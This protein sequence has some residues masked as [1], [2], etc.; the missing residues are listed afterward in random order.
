VNG[1]DIVKERLR[2]LA[3]YV[4]D[5]QDYRAQA[6]SFQVYQDNKMLRR[7]V[8]R[9]L[10]VALEICLDIGRRLITLDGFRYPADNQDVFRVL[11]EER[12]VSE[13]LLSALLDMARFRNL[14]VHNYAHID[15]AKV[16]GILRKHLGDFDAFAR[17]I[18]DYLQ[19][20][21]GTLSDGS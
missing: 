16:Y 2:L 10:Q 3:E 14:V 13:P 19:P 8:E 5:L 1:D 18:V 12:I 6:T 15:D 17:A 11:G 4:N 9:S 7:A 21:S 20:H